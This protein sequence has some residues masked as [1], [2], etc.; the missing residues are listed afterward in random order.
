MLYCCTVSFLTP[1]NGHCNFVL[2]ADEHDGDDDVDGA[3]NDD[4]SEHET[5]F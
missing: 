4:D 3:D 5:F 1:Q 2:A